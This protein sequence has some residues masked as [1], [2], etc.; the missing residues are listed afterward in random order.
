M[1]VHTY[2]HK[3]PLRYLAQQGT[4]LLIYALKVPNSA[5]RY[6]DL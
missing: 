6:L 1:C 4:F 2:T 3:Q 5:M